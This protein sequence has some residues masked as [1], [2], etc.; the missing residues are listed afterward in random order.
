MLEVAGDGI[1]TFPLDHHGLI[2]SVCKD[3]KIA[4]RINACL[5]VHEKRDVSPGL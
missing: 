4:D 5:G 3:L 2:A 1:K